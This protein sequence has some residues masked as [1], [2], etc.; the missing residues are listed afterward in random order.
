MQCLNCH[1]DNLP[2]DTDYC[3]RC[4]IHL[5][6]LLR[7]VLPAGTGLRGDAYCVDYAIGRGSF[8][9][10]YRARRGIL[11][12]TFAIKEF[13]PTEFVIRDQSD[14]SVSVLEQHQYFFQRALHRFRNEGQILARLDHPNIVWRRANYRPRRWSA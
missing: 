6:S 2:P 3:P 13:Y 4:K 10:T 5:P 12:E 8:G 9:V 14:Q 1:Y 7:D 11:Q